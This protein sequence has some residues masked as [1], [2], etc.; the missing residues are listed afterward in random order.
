M[1]VPFQIT[2][3]F[4]GAT[5]L[6]LANPDSVNPATGV[7]E[8][9]PAA[10]VGVFDL[11][12]S[13]LGFNPTWIQIIGVSS[14]GPLISARLILQDGGIQNLIVPGSA[15]GSIWNVLAPQGSSLEIDGG[16]G[17]VY[18][19]LWGVSSK[20]WADLQCCHQFAPQN[21]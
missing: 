19:S 1:S 6:S 10:P 11:A 9:T 18:F 15:N 7:R 13:P 8:F 20:V 14:A 4:D 12:T 5:A 21:S 2:G 16:L 3:T 17:D